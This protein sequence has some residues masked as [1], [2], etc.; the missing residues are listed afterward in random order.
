MDARI[1][2]LILLF[3]CL[4]GFSARAQYMHWDRLMEDTLYYGQEYFPER[5]TVASSGPGQVWDFRSLKSPFAVSRNIF[6]IGE[7]EGK[8]YAYLQQGKTTEAVMELRGDQALIVQ[9]IE[10]NPVCAGM[11]LTYALSPAH[12]QF[13]KGVLGATHT[14]RGRQQSAFAWPRHITCSWTPTPFPDS[15]RIT[16]TIHEQMAVDGEG[17]LYLP[18]EVASVLRQQ[19]HSR[20]AVSIE[21]KHGNAWRD[22]TSQVPGVRLVEQREL[23]RYVDAVSGVMLAEVDLLDH[24]QIGSVVF[25]THPLVTRILAE[26]PTRPDILAYPNPTYGLVR[27][28]LRDLAHGSYKLKIFNILGVPVRD[29]DIRVDHDRKTIHVDLSELQRGTYLYRLQDAAGRALRTKKFV[30]I[31]T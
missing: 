27:F 7:R 5:I 1:N 14:Y 10:D 16:Y 30:L 11:R 25:K 18:T 15:C 6:Q 21:V 29:L 24:G 17:T 26:E 31:A 23:R 13:F 4:A 9:R 22:V 12:R 20:R 19:I 8:S 2:R 28:Q 3:A